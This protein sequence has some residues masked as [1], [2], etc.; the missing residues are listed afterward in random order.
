M[1]T[2]TARTTAQQ[3]SDARPAA[4]P[5]RAGDLVRTIAAGTPVVSGQ[6]RVALATGTWWWSDEVYR[7]YGYE[8][9]E[10]KP[11]RAVLRARRHP[12]D[13]DRVVHEAVRALRAGHPFTCAQRIVDTH[14]R[15]RTLMVSG[16]A[17]R[18]ASGPELVGQVADVT[19]LQREAVA[20]EARRAVDGAMAS[21]ATIEQAR[22]VLMAVHGLTEE[23]ALTMLTE[24]AATAGA[25]LRSVAAQ[26]LAG[27]A[28]PGAL[29]APAARQVRRVLAEVVPTKRSRVHDPLLTRRAA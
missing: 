29:G 16:Q 20:R 25:D 23:D 7:L 9:D 22:G 13:Q 17:V 27:L 26:L 11:G 8:P 18:T 14:G 4:V 1:T 12:D 3:A 15:T 28:E 6:Y 5:E 19:P 24:R 2:P 10:V 21:A